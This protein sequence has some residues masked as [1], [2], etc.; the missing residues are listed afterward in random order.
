MHEEKESYSTQN[1][2]QV[3]PMAMYKKGKQMFARYKLELPV[4]IPLGSAGSRRR[5]KTQTTRRKKLR[6]TSSEG[7]PASDVILRYDGVGDDDEVAKMLQ[8][9]QS[10]QLQ[11][12]S[13]ADIGEKIRGHGQTECEKE[14]AKARIQED[15]EKQVEKYKKELEEY[16]TKYPADYTGPLIAAPV[17]RE[18]D[19]KEEQKETVVEL[20]KH[21]PDKA[22]RY[23]EISE[24]QLGRMRMNT[25]EM[26]PAQ[27]DLAAM[28]VASGMSMGASQP[29]MMSLMGGSGGMN[30]GLGMN[31]MN[32]MGMSGMN[33]MGMSGISSGMMSQP[34]MVMS[35]GMMPWTVER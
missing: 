24:D 35:P 5:A 15:Y 21:A 25:Q 18:D 17:T 12:G 32:G 28:S 26:R 8:E 2:A 27:Y 11:V 33:G 22:V 9:Q 6:K 23:E 13:R 30:S 10:C 7:N 3:I 29:Q 14:A 16:Y 34:G 20:N 1:G 31:G 4:E 19:S